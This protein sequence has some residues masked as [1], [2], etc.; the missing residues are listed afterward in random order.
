MILQDR[1]FGI[2]YLTLSYI[3]QYIG[4]SASGD[5]S[6]KIWRIINHRSWKILQDRQVRKSFETEIGHIFQFEKIIHG[7]LTIGSGGFFQKWSCRI[8]SSEFGI[9]SRPTLSNTSKNH[10][11]AIVFQRYGGFYSTDPEK[12]CRIA[13]HLTPGLPSNRLPLAV[14]W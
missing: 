4:K 9:F 10:P 3:F 1:F 2:S 13:V 12:S 14:R 8:A 7:S 11:Q 6:P 5:F